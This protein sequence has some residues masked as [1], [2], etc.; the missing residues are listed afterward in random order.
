[1]V[2]TV[3]SVGQV[4]TIYTDLHKS[5][6]KVDHG[7]LLAKLH[8]LGLRDPLLTWLVRIDKAVLNI[9]KVTSGVP[10]GSLIYHLSPLLFL[11]FIND[12]N[13]YFNTWKFLMFADNMK[14]FMPI[15]STDDVFSVQCDLDQFS[16]WCLLNGMSPNTSKYVHI[17]FNRSN[18]MFIII[19]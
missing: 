4:D 15:C 13:R 6:D 18:L 12:I 11:L 19:I 17:S 16:A 5:F 8:N 1:M 10:Q 9:I 2:D 7:L 14:M 3:S